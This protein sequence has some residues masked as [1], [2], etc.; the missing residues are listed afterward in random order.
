MGVWGGGLY[1]N[2]LAMDLRSTIGAVLRLP[3]DADQLVEILCGTQP[4]A[5]NNA[6]DEEHTTFWLVLADQFSRRGVASERVQAK[7]LQIIDGGEDLATLSRLGARPQDLRK[8]EKLLTELR[9]RFVTP[10]KEAPRKVLREPQPLLMQTGDAL[11]FPTCNGDN[12]NP[13][14]GSREKNVRWVQ[15]GWG[16]MVVMECGRAFDF[17]AWYRPAT[18]AEIR[19]EK[20]ALYSLRGPLLWN[21]SRPGTCSAI[22]F[23][24]ME[25][26]KIGVLPVDP[27]K[28]IEV[29]PRRFRTE[30]AAA[31]QDIS[32]A[33]SMKSV[34]PGS[35][36]PNHD[37][38]HRGRCTT[39][40]SIDEVFVG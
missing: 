32:I 19:T 21:L 14:F 20:P 16:A 9:T 11:V 12:I 23:R 1:S 30:V 8:R 25:L 2:D 3:F 17:L 40:A 38:A 18:L 29:Y 33:N 13:Y 6:A 15:N 37:G 4:S 27:A 34:P 35:A 24:K 39:L 22:H 31:V 28:A 7:A 36:I 5:A 26:E 10:L